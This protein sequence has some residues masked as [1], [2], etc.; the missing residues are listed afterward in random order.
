MPSQGTLTTPKLDAFC[1]ASDIHYYEGALQKSKK[2][3]E[4]YNSSQVLANVPELGVQTS[5]SPIY[6]CKRNNIYR[7]CLPLYQHLQAIAILPVSLPIM[8]TATNKSYY[9]SNDIEQ[10]VKQKLVLGEHTIMVEAAYC[11]EFTT[12]SRVIRE[13][14][15]VLEHSGKC[16]CATDREANKR[17]VR[18]EVF[19]A[20]QQS[21]FL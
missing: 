13:I 19:P 7:I 2:T 8:E 6:L 3:D 16:D 15:R 4:K 20:N 11:V 5:L 12:L 10:T 18:S 14:S 21:I 9:R 17:G 1:I